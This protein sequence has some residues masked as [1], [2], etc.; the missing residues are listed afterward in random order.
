MVV[1]LKTNNRTTAWGKLRT[2]PK[3]SGVLAGVC[4]QAR[5]CHVLGSS[6]QQQW[7]EQNSGTGVDSLAFLSHVATAGI[8]E[9]MTVRMAASRLP[10][11]KK[12]PF[13]AFW[14]VTCSHLS[15]SGRERG[16]SMCKLHLSAWFCSHLHIM[17][18]QTPIMTLVMFVLAC[19]NVFFVW[20]IQSGL[21]ICYCIRATWKGVSLVVERP[22]EFFLANHCSFI[23]RF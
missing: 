3:D 18:S 20:Q 23:C 6:I 1:L 21:S 7:G 11:R 2:L 15:E 16:T 4:L 8:I 14:L 22:E 19:Y 17:Y 10:G 13:Q 9:R 5:W 12:M